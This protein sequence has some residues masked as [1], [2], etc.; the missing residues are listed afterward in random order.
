MSSLHRI[1]PLT[2]KR[3]DWEAKQKATQDDTIEIK[4]QIAAL[5]RA[6]RAEQARNDLLAFTQFTMPDPEAMN[7]ITRS[8][9]AAKQFHKEVAK[10]L[11]G[12]ERGDITQLI[13]CMP[14]RHGKT[15][16]ATKRFAAWY[17]GKHP[18]HDIAVASY[19]D[20]MAEDM[21]ADTRA[22]L[23][24]AQYK[25]VFPK[26]GL[27]RG[28]T[29][30]S[31]IQTQA[32]GRMVF[33]GRGGALTGRGANCLVGETEVMT[34]YGARQIR[35]VRVGEEVLSYDERTGRSVWRRI[36]AVSARPQARIFRVSDND[37]RVF[38]ATADHRVYAG[39]EWVE[40]SKLSPGDRLVCA[41]RES[42][43]PTGVRG[44]EARAERVGKFL[45]LE[46]LLGCRNERRPFWETVVCAMR[47]AG[48]KVAGEFRF[49]KAGAC[50]LFTGLQGRGAA[51]RTG[52]ADRGA[53]APVRAVSSDVRSAQCSDPV[54]LAP[55]CGTGAF[56]DYARCKQPSL[57]E[58]GRG[59]TQR[60]ACDAPVSGASSSYLG[61][62]WASLRR[63]LG[64]RKSGGASHRR[65]PAEQS[66]VELGDAL[67]PL[68]QASSF[69]RCGSS[70]V[71]A[72]EDLRREAV[73]YDIQVE[74]TECF[75][76]N[77]VLVHNCLLIDDLFKD[78][79]EARS[80]AIRDQAW[81]WFTKVAMTRRMGKKLVVITM[82]RWHSDDI[83]GRLTDPENQN[84]SAEEA[85]S[86][87]IIRLPALAEEDD[88]LGRPV[89]E[90]LWPENYGTEYLRQ[91]QRIDPLGFAALFQQ[92]PTVADGILFRRENIR[93]YDTLPDNLRYYAS[94]DH[95]VG[96]KERNDPS[97]F[98]KVGIDEDSNIYL[99]ETAW[100]RMAADEQV[101]VML[102]MAAGKTAPL[103]WWA[104]RGHISKSIGPFL[105]KR[106][107][108]TG[109]YINVVEVTP[110]VDK[111]QRAQS[112]AARVA[113]GKVFFPRVSTWTEKAVNELLAFPNGNHDDF[114]DALAY[115]GLG[116]QNQFAAS[117]PRKV[118][119]APAFGTLAWVREHEKHAER[120]ALRRRASGGF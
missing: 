38:D 56:R 5:E 37:G 105:H 68:P 14:P 51:G 115:I 101:E 2:G 81:N 34:P 35:H 98:L 53:H 61:S 119:K 107:Q 104:E 75:F 86:W 65:E 33:V 110:A 88:P 52:A 108:E 17:S 19:S 10:A 85:A 116:L 71:A 89:G 70:Y 9:Y 102:T 49:A 36:E 11:E 117:G 79:E 73:V 118:E 120:D 48:T 7:D 76:A 27:R 67:Q 12:V 87:K 100:K 114:V 44:R 94:S 54:L 58:W 80:Q 62:G 23:N 64:F 31:N 25:Q 4:R 13:F 74:E 42:R 20:T 30:K 8:R 21:G 47:R 41:M 39:G 50:F 29:A 90:P 40:A 84:Y 1:N 3:R 93:Y 6:A 26:Y 113:M 28:G 66:R 92:R 78:H 24:S 91:Q 16:M 55:L 97:C 60:T 22:I 106:A 59:A 18:E 95:A 111:E 99:T 82:T 63:V 83:I 69:F 77:G 57:A 72:V 32:G 46:R 15:E 43:Y 96:T 45:L 112:I 103:Q 109:R